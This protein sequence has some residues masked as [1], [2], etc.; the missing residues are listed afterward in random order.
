LTKIFSLAEGEITHAIDEIV[1][2]LNMRENM[3]EKRLHEMSHHLGDG[4]RVLIE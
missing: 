2:V 3:I 1:N 4:E